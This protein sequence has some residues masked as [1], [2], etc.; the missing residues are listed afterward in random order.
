[1][2]FE[3]N[4]NPKKQINGRQ[5]KNSLTEKKWKPPYRIAAAILAV[6][7]L[8]FVWQVSFI[9][10]ENLRIVEDSLNVVRLDVLPV[11]SPPNEKTVEIS[12]NSAAKKKEVENVSKS[13]PIKYTPSEHKSLRPQVK[14]KTALDP[15]S[16]RLRRAEKLLT[17]F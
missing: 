8:H 9:Q 6:F 11:E 10:K 1:M 2:N 5:P 3:P 7:V 16:A 15:T 17:G 12:S 4:Q 13:V 14:K